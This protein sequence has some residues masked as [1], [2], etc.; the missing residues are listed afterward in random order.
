M[1]TDIAQLLDLGLTGALVVA[2][3]VL[4]RDNRAMRE[5]L[6]NI[7]REV[8]GLKAQLQATREKRP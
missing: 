3:V 5:Q 1:L 6:V 2:V 8:A 7:L 4:W